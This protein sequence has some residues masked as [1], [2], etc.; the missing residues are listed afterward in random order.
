V[1]KQI[2]ILQAVVATAALG[3]AAQ[4]QAHSALLLELAPSPD[5]RY[6]GGLAEQSGCLQSAILA[7]ATATVSRKPVI[8]EELYVG[9]MM[10]EQYGNHDMGHWL[11]HG[12]H[13]HRPDADLWSHGHEISDS[14]PVCDPTPVPLPSGFWLLSSA[15]FAG[16]ILR[17]RKPFATQM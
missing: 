4:C 2:G 8:T 10:P 9:K 1:S 5:S 17:T 12:R 14:R 6:C 11:S 16:I 13:D 3:I 15:L 7:P